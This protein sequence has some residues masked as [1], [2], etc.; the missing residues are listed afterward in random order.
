MVSLSDCCFP[1]SSTYVSLYPPISTCFCPWPSTY[2]YI[3]LCLCMSTKS[4]NDC[5]LHL[6][7]PMSTYVNVCWPIIPVSVYLN[8]PYFPWSFYH[9]SV[10]YLFYSPLLFINTSSHIPSCFNLYLFILFVSIF[11]IFPFPYTL[12]FGWCFLLTCNYI[13]GE[14]KPRGFQSIAFGINLV[15]IYVLISLALIKWHDESRK[16][17]T[18][19]YSL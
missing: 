1:N 7:K 2:T 6:F 17:F 19:S 8:Y 15:V 12:V 13:I 16:E 5:N 4:T 14:K 3:Y 9:C 18:S 10:I 11:K